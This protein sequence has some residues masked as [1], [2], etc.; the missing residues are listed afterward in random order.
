MA[1]GPVQML[2]LGFEEPHFTGEVLGELKRLKEADIVRLIDAIAIAKDEDGNVTVL[3]Q[4]DLSQ[5]E[6]EEFGAIVG[7]LIGL[8]AEGEEG[9]E[10][11]ALAG[12]E[13]MADGHLLGDEDVWYA[14]D[15]IPNGSAAAVALI[16]HR[17]AI[18]FRDAIARA[19]GIALADE[20]IHP[21]DLV[22]VGLVAAA[23]AEGAA[24]E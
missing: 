5:D 20:W 14:S 11:G 12:A 13:A 21:T 1:F 7:A 3:Q 16:E 23:E 19:G 15:V 9:A 10:A 22:A 24:A 18:P 4:S 6:A 2:V 17:W 8:G